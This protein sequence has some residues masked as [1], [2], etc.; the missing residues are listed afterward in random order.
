M[1]AV[2]RECATLLLG[3]SA[4]SAPWLLCLECG[5]ECCDTRVR[6]AFAGRKH[7]ERA[8]VAVPGVRTVNAVTRECAMILLGVSTKSAPWLLCLECVP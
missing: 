8:M 4:M 7:Y 6:H 1:N 2:T 3:E 5:C